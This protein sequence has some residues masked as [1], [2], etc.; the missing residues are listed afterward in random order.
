MSTPLPPHHDGGVNVPYAISGEVGDASHCASNNQNNTAS[1]TSKKRKHSTQTA[2]D[3][4]SNKLHRGVD[5]NDKSSSNNIST[6][7]E[8]SAS[9]DDAISFT[10][11]QHPVNGD[12][13][14]Y[15][16]AV[17]PYGVLDWGKLCQVPNNDFMNILNH[18]KY[19]TIAYLAEDVVGGDYTIR[20]QHTRHLS[21]MRNSSVRN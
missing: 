18:Y 15:Y 3:D 9:E 21:G 2:N 4:E 5:D 6:A 13:G 12:R 10:A 11:D 19:D 20:A 1:H 14:S 16:Y 17:D 7:S 8:S